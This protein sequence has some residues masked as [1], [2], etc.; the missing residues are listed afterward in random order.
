MV[1]FSHV[2]RGCN[3]RVLDMDIAPQATWSYSYSLSV[4]SLSGRGVT[5][6]MSALGAGDSE[7]ESRRPD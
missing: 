6:N 4:S 5:A 1:I 2:I 3:V 7:F